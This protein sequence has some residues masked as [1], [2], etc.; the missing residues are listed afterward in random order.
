MDMLLAEELDSGEIDK[1]NEL[2]GS[3]GHLLKKVQNLLH[4]NDQSLFFSESSAEPSDVDCGLVMY[5]KSH[6]KYIVAELSKNTS[7]GPD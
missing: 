3:T 5:S 4:K 1:I 2:S 6:S 7:N